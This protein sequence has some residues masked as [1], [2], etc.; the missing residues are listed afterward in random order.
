[1]IIST[2]VSEIVVISQL[3]VIILPENTAIVMFLILKRTF[4]LFV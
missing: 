4:G 1:M 2:A 3:K